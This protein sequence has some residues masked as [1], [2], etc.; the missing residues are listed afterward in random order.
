MLQLPAVLESKFTSLAV[1][2]LGSKRLPFTCRIPTNP[3]AAGTS[4]VTTFKLVDHKS[5]IRI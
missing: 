5:L 2:N 3:T 4:E 1:P